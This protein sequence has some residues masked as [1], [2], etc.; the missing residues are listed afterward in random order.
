MRDL[1]PGSAL[2]GIGFAALN[3]A[4][5]V[6]F[7]DKLERSSQTYGSLGI[8]VTVLLYLFV[9]GQVLVISAITNTLWVDRSAILAQ[10]HG[11]ARHERSVGEL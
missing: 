2:G 1:L 11:E 7:A 4:T 6:Y 8:A 3:I 9:V 10:A 5:V